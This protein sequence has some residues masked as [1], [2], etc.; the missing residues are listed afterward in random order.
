MSPRNAADSHAAPPPEPTRRR[1]SLTQLGVLVAAAAIPIFPVLTIAVA[2]AYSAYLLLV[3]PSNLKV[4]KGLG[5]VWVVAL[6]GCGA[7][8]LSHTLLAPERPLAA[9]D[10]AP[11]GIDAYASGNL[12]FN[13]DLAGTQSWSS[14]QGLGAY[15]E[16][17]EPGV[18]RLSVVEGARFT[19]VRNLQEVRLAAGVSYGARAVVRHDGTEFS[20]RL[21]FR[22]REGWQPA[23][24]ST[25]EVA[26]GLV[27]L[28]GELPVQEAAIRLRTLHIAELDGDWTYIDVA[29]ASLHEGGLATNEA[30][31]SAAPLRPWLDGVW[32]WIGTALTLTACGL[33]ARSLRGAGWSGALSFGLLCGLGVQLLVTVGQLL[34]G[35]GA[36]PSGTLGDPNL[37]AHAAVIAGLASV[38]LARGPARTAGVAAAIVAPIVALSGSD[39]GLVGLGLG[40]LLVAAALMKRRRPFLMG[41]AA[42]AVAVILLLGGPRLL[43]FL[44]ADSNNTARLQAWET[45]TTLAA[46][47]PV[48]GVGTGNFAHFYEF[49]VPAEQGPRF[50][51]HHAHSLFGV[52]AESGLLVALALMG[53]LSLLVAS[54]FRRG[55]PLLG[56]V[57][58]VALLLNLVDLT[59]FSPAM[60]LPWWVAHA[61]SVS[62]EG[63]VAG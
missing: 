53:G 11:F 35:D 15:A 50:R 14:G 20:G 10:F 21:V 7:Q 23:A 9:A 32:W 52:G 22:T 37:L 46:E 58:G 12:I 55:Q 25:R 6:L 60:M 3:R 28:E 48:A 26:P 49:A 27:V 13:S 1:A 38:A 18:W 42:V 24:T 39:A 47:Y 51:N 33:A 40:V 36:R 45:V 57:L 19:E 41:A 59:L 5:Y 30:F 29:L 62:G 43:D 17:I 61:D 2:A 44:R 4:P 8:L 16:A 34:G 31:V 54:Y 63:S 56:A